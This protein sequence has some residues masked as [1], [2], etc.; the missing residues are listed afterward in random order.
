MKIGAKMLFLGLIISFS[1]TTK[2]GIHEQHE[3][4]EASNNPNQALYDEVMAVH[5]EVMPKED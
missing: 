4:V 2:S 5:D 3:V 1:C